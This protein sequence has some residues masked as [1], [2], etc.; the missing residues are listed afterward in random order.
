MVGKTPFGN[1]GADEIE[2][3]FMAILNYAKTGTPTP[4]FPWFFPASA[5]DFI[6]QLLKATPEERMSPQ[7]MFEHPFLA[8]VTLDDLERKRL[9]APYVPTIDDPTD[10]SNF[11]DDDAEDDSTDDEAEGDEGEESSS[12]REVASEKDEML[13]QRAADFRL[14]PN[15]EPIV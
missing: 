5:F 14:Y 8:E 10:T 1:D 3:L 2:D 12:F 13:K 11:E 4:K 9:P 15:F 7:L 6:S